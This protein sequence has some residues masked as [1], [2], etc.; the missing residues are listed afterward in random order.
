VASIY[1]PMWSSVLHYYEIDPTF[2]IIDIVTDYEIPHK[3]TQYQTSQWLNQCTTSKDL[4]SVSNGSRFGP[5]KRVS[6]VPDQSKHFYT[7]SLGR[8]RPGHV[9]VNPRISPGL[10][11]RVGSNLW[12]CI[13]SFTLNVAFRYGTVNRKILSFVCDGSISSY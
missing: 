5:Q 6:S 1:H 12:F 10:A 11:R 13:S 3:F 8:P 9:P 2:K 4:N 7:L